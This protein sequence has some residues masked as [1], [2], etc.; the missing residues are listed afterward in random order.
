MCFA[1]ELFV[2]AGPCRDNEHAQQVAPVRYAR[3]RRRLADDD[4]IELRVV[5]GVEEVLDRPVVAQ[6][7]MQ[8][9]ETIARPRRGARQPIF[10]LRKRTVAIVNRGLRYRAKREPLH[11]AEAHRQR[12]D[13]R[14]DLGAQQPGDPAVRDH[15][16]ERLD[17]SWRAGAA[18][19][20]CAPPRRNR[21]TPTSALP[22]ATRA[23][24][25]PRLYASCRP[26]FI[27]CAPTG[28]VDMRG[29]AQQEAATIAKARRGPVRD[30]IGRKPR[31]RLD[32]Q[33]RAGLAAQRRDDVVERDI[34][35]IA[36]R[37]AAGCRRSASDPLRASGRTG[38]I[39]C[40]T[41]TR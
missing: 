20:E 16:P 31:A 24:F 38:G 21:A 15:Q 6:P 32:R 4:E 17:R 11:A 39:R 1:R 26:V 22:V 36:Q 19:P 41:G 23:S 5:E 12:C 34:L 29:V 14:D 40:A 27:P 30:A 28:T 3:T 2:V 18:R 7:E 37:L 8:P 9:R 25:Q 35:P 13:A 33:R 10:R